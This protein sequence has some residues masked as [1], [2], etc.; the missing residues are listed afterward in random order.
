MEGGK[1]QIFVVAGS[2]CGSVGRA[3]A[4]NTRDLQ[5]ESQHW[6]NLSINVQLKRRK[7]NILVVEHDIRI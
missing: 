3:I 5:F 6:Q 1:L 7:K 2:G 4:S